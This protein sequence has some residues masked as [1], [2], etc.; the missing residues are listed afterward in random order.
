MQDA[1]IVVFA[2]DDDGVVDGC[3]SVFYV[4]C[5]ADHRGEE[6]PAVLWWIVV[7]MGVEEW[8]VL[9]VYLFKVIKG[10]HELLF[11]GV[12]HGDMVFHSGKT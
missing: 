6:F 8:F 7:I 10:N 2:K 1:S 11:L 9:E 3:I 5:P 4:V 12:S